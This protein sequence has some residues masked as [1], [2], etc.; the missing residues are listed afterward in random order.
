M[1]LSRRE[2]A[3]E[4]LEILEELGLELETEEKRY[5]FDILS[6][7]TIYAVK[8][9]C[10]L[11]MRALKDESLKEE[12]LDS[13]MRMIGLEYFDERKCYYERRFDD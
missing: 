4:I 13:F 3:M 1:N 11:A 12:I 5:L 8:E 9:K 7:M 10:R 2:V 6:D